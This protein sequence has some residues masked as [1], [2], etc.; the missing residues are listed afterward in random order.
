MPNQ[1]T[2]PITSIIAHPVLDWNAISKEEQAFRDRRATS[3]PSFGDRKKP[4][5][6]N[7]LGRTFG[8][9]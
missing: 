6:K 1:P 7:R 4:Q 5:A 8:K 2:K 3:K 9:R